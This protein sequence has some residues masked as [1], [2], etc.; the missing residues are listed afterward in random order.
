MIAQSVELFGF[1]I[2][3]IIISLVAY[4]LWK[5]VHYFLGGFAFVALF[6][7]LIFIWTPAPLAPF[8]EPLFAF[9]LFLWNAVLTL[10]SDS[11]RF[12]RNL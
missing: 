2:T 6:L 3:L 1:F 4:V 8:V 11:L 7:L 10:L 9:L 12:V 5:A